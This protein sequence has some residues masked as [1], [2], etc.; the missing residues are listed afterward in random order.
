MNKGSDHSSPL[1]KHLGIRILDGLSAERCQ[2]QV[3]I[4][5]HH[6]NALGIVHGGL[7]FSLA[8][9]AF[10]AAEHLLENPFVAMEMHTRFLRPAKE[11]QTLTATASQIHHGRLTSCYEVEVRDEKDRLIAKLMATGHVLGEKK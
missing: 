6:T 11:G 3:D 7:I 5:E 9:A 10:G 4:E 2:A 1:C 8:D